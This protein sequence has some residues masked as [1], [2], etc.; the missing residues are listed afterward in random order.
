MVG[1]WVPVDKTLLRHDSQWL[2]LLSI[3]EKV[4]GSWQQVQ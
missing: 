1:M 2:E 4:D 3:Y